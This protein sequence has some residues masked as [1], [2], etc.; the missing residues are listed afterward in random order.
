MRALQALQDSDVCLIMVDAT[1]GLEAQDMNI[2]SLALKYKKGI[3]LM[4]NKWDLIDK[5]TNTMQNF[6]R[7]L[8]EK[9]GTLNWI[10]KI[11]TSVTDKKRIFKPL[12]WLFRY[13]RTESVRYQP[14]N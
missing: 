1:R 2:I 10:P 7:E 5:E 8:D 11:F 6:K 3:M 13:M 9:L 14:L 4:M 12:K